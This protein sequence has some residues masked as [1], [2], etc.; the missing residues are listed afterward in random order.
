[1]GA[2]DR[3]R[4]DSET[5]RRRTPRVGVELWVQEQCEAGIYY[6]RVTN[7]SSEG[8]FVEKKIPFRVGQVM[9][10]RLDLPGGKGPL[11]ARSRVVDNYHDGRD[12]LV[13]AGFQFL[14]MDRETR[15]SIAAVVAG[16]FN[17][18]L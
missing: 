16:S 7:L 12:N 14:E 11:R 13:G 9:T 1:M 6:H 4:G 15:R 8:F 18:P 17:R 2:I 5:E 10:L 3:S